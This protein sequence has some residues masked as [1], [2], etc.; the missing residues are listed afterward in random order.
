MTKSIDKNEEMKYRKD[1]ATKQGG[2]TGTTEL[3]QVSSVL[4]VFTKYFFNDVDNSEL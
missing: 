2:T 1:I 3:K 4:K